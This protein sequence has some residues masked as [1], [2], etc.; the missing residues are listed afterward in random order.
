MVGQVTEHIEHAG[1]CPEATGYNRGWCGA[2]V[3]RRTCHQRFNNV[4][5]CTPRV[6]CA[7][8]FFALNFSFVPFKKKKKKRF[9]TVKLG[10]EKQWEAPGHAM[11]CWGSIF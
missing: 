3:A 8:L 1:E 9:K 2:E 5:C 6:G 10:V 7:A 4:A 11:T